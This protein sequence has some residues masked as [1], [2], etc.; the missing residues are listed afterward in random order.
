MVDYIY[1][2][3]RCINCN[4]MYRRKCNLAKHEYMCGLLDRLY[5]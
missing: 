4:K 1:D 3:E 2:V 5:S